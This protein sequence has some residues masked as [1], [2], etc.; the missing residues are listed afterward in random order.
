MRKLLIVL[1]MLLLSAGLYG[2]QKFN[3]T[4]IDSHDN[5]PLAG[6]QVLANG[7][8]TG[9][10]SDADGHFHL[11]L[12]VSTESLQFSFMGY[13]SYM[14]DLKGIDPDKHFLIRLVQIPLYLDE[15]IIYSDRARERFSPVSFTTIEASQILAELGDRP[16][17]EV[18]QRSPGI[19]ATRDG[20]GSGDA[21]LSIRGF[22]QENIAVL[23][24]GVPIN[25][26][27]NGLVY[28]NN[29]MGLTE[30][31]A[32]IQLQRGIGAS[33]VALNSVGGTV[34][35]ITRTTELEKG[36]SFSHHFTSYGNR[37]TTFNYNTGKMDNGWA[38]SMLGSRTFG[39]GYI[40]GTYVDGWAYFLGLGKQFGANH[41]LMF[42]ALGGPERHGQRNF[43]LSQDEIDR[44]GHTYNKEWG[45]YNGK[46][47][48]ASEN[49]YH[50]PHLSLNHYWGIGQRSVLSTA[51]YITPGH[52]GGKWNDSFSFGPGVFNFRNPSGQI[53]WNAIYD[54]NQSHDDYYIQQNGDT[55]TG[56][57]K[58]VQTHFL[59]SHIWAGALSSYELEITPQTKLITGLH[60]RYFKSQL[61]QKVHDLLG[62]AFYID[63]YSWS[64]AGVAGRGEIKMPGDI[65]RINNGALLHT[66]SLFA[67]LEHRIGSMNAFV[68]GTV[69]DNRYRRHDVYNYPD[70]KWSDWVNIPAFD[71]KAGLNMNIDRLQQAYLNVG[72][73]NKAPYYKFVFG[74]FTNV[75]VR[76]RNNEK[77]TTAE[78]GYVYSNK[79]NHLKTNI[80][81]THWQDVSFLSDELIQ[82]ED[83]KQTRAMV[84]GLNARHMG[85]ELELAAKLHQNFT[86]GAL[87]SV[88]NWKWT[89][90]VEASLFNDNDVVVDTV[91]VYASGLFVGGHPQLHLGLFVQ[92]KLLGFTEL[93]LEW[94]YFDRHYAA[95]EPSGRQNPD[96]RDQSYKLP[97]VQ[98]VNAYL[99]FP[100]SIGE[101]QMQ[102]FA[103][104]YN[105]FDEIYILK[106]EDGPGHGIEGFRG[107]WSFGRNFSFG[108]KYSF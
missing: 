81:H 25:G 97:A 14:L 2:Q 48:N 95:F 71:I 73:F 72:H 18:F 40:D 24:N 91:K 28:W 80:Y 13:E 9:T 101:N 103:A 83:N 21:T 99:S 7:T 35:I 69:S 89:N 84:S 42:T 30:A 33:K 57:S 85:L 106:G 98:V 87:A 94:N 67:Q 64:L 26:A 45:A 49:F 53:D 77:V 108:L 19:Y 65:I 34:N 100:L 4:V 93:K 29:W 31:A 17:P 46:I 15:V 61:R 41:K 82:L 5:N 11:S 50:K 102:V 56:F 44:Y 76:D 92:A 70:D 62:G 90:D 88:G 23:L 37:R 79:G 68:G 75:P 36:G 54:F 16:L 1:T 38:L 96:N 20:G 51:V 3:G 58:V 52:G 43:R 6:V 107:Y 27:E 32:T 60:Y 39:P 47:N 104:A 59:A 105:L 74:N 10:I 55:V 78:M 22:Q 63:D 86:I 12:P 66:T 8:N